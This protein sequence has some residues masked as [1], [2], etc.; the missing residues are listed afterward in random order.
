MSHRYTIKHIWSLFGENQYSWSFSKSVTLY[1]VDPLYKHIVVV[2]VYYQGGFE[3]F[4]IW[5]KMWNWRWVSRSLPYVCSRVW[6]WCRCC[7]Q[8]LW[9][10]CA[11]TMQEFS[12]FWRR[13]TSPCQLVVEVSWI[14]PVSQRAVW[15]VLGPCGI[16]LG[17]RGHFSVLCTLLS[18]LHLKWSWH[19]GGRLVDGCNVYGI[20]CMLSL[21]CIQQWYNLYSRIEHLLSCNCNVP[22]KQ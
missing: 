14:W 17:L 21:L 16:D 8:W 1:F 4:S 3:G 10:C 6:V 2:V 13:L 19:R 20:L 12:E 15:F 5:G 7:P 22:T 11:F 18:F 9:F